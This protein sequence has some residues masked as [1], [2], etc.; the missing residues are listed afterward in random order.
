MKKTTLNLKLIF[1]FLT[2]YNTFPQKTT[3]GEREFKSPIY[4]ILCHLVNIHSRMCYF[5]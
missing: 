5:N 4:F 3:K 1:N 2:A